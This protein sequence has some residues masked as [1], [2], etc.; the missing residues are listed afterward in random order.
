VKYDKCRS[1]LRERQSS[2]K[3]RELLKVLS[4]LGFKVKDGKKGGHKLYRHPDISSFAG[5]DFN[6]GHSHGD[7]VKPVYVKGILRVIEEF[8]TELREALGE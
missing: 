6:C 1:T 8:E 2:L 4:D 5:G 3:C 7:Q